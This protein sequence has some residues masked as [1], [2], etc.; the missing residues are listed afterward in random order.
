MQLKIPNLIHSRNFF[1]MSFIQRLKP[2]IEN[3]PKYYFLHYFEMN[4]HNI[5]TI[6]ITELRTFTT[7]LYISGLEK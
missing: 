5:D 7:A 1:E 2:F 3:S 4:S 6:S